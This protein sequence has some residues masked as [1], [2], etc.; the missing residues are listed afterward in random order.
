MTGEKRLLSDDEFATLVRSRDAIRL[1]A[2]GYAKK[3]EAADDEE[4]REKYK[5]YAEDLRYWYKDS[6]ILIPKSK[7][8]YEGTYICPTCKCRIGDIYE[9]AAD[10]NLTVSCCICC[11]QTFNELISTSDN[12]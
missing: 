3:A 8:F 1:I 12:Y 7:F 6:E 5:R 9:A 10:A 4:S 11:G 2:E